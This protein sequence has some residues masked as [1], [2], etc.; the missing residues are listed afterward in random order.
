MSGETLEVERSYILDRCRQTVAIRIA[1]RDGAG[2]V[3]TYDQ[4]TNTH[5]RWAPP[6][7]EGTYTGVR[8]E[9]RDSFAAL[10][11]DGDTF[12]ECICGDMPP[13]LVNC[14]TKIATTL[15]QE[16]LDDEAGRYDCAPSEQL[17][18]QRGG[19]YRNK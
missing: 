2:A 1:H 16:S 3:Y 4:R 7:N 5:L 11:M 9:L 15:G 14:E 12:V 19:R 17:Y 13:R 10:S 18:G 8:G 6:N